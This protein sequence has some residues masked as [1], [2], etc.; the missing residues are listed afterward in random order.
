MGRLVEGCEPWTPGALVLMIPGSISG[1]GICFGSPDWEC[2][3]SFCCTSRWKAAISCCSMADSCSSFREAYRQTYMVITNT[4]QLG[5]VHKTQSQQ[6]ELLS[7]LP[8]RLRFDCRCSSFS[9]FTAHTYD[10]CSL[11]NNVDES[12]LWNWLLRRRP[13]E[14][15]AHE[16]IVGSLLTC[17]PSYKREKLE[18]PV[19]SNLT[20]EPSTSSTWKNPPVVAIHTKNRQNRVSQGNLL[21]SGEKRENIRMRDFWKW[22]MTTAKHTLLWNL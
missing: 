5:L 1:S 16:W 7:C 13:T 12:I 8:H 14:I 2:S 9:R 6:S 22:A 19:S 10:H 18:C 17:Y 3:T 4:N 21:F 15:R 11:E 20:L